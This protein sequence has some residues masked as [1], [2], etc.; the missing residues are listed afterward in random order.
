MSERCYFVVIVVIFFETGF[1]YVAQAGFELGIL[2]SQL[3]KCW[4]DRHVP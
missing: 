1:Q 4:D 3:P 2:L